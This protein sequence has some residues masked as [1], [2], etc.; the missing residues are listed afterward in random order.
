MLEVTDAVISVFGADRVGMHLAPRGDS[1]DMSDS[2]PRE[3]FGYVAREL[4]KRKIAFI[5]TREYLGPDSISSELKE[6]F[7]GVL[8]ANEKL[9]RESAEELIM[10]GKADAVSFGIPFISNPD[11]PK[12]FLENASLNIT[13]F[14]KLYGTG[15]EGYTDYPS[16]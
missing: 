9:T 6:Q 2:N 11:L 4:G 10:S 8:I 1:H 14:D 12:R 7:G 3:T 13:N 5:F 16:L 15:T